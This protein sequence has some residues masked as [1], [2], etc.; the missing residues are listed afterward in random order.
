MRIQAKILLFLPSTAVV[1]CALLSPGCGDESTPATSGSDAGADAEFVSNCGHPG[2][3]GN[4]LGVGKFCLSLSDCSENVQAF[5]CTQIA[6]PDNYFCTFACKADGG[7]DQC[8]EAASCQC[9]GNQCG[10]FPDACNHSSSDAG[11]D[12]AADMDAGDA[13]ID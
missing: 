12:G 4:S 7:V 3:V 11:A 2:D 5:L 10:C 8:G 1:A 9:S 13:S 6:N